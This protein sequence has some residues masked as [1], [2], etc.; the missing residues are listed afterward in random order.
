MKDEQERT[1]EQGLLHGKPLSRREFLRFAG[2]AGAVMGVGGG[3]SG[4]LAACG[5]GST[6]TTAAATTTA[7][8]SS[9]T[10]ATTATASSTASGSLVFPKNTYT[11][12][13]KTVTTSDG[14]KEVTYRL[15]KHLT[16]VANPV[17]A[18]YQSLNVSVPVKIP[19][20]CGAAVSAAMLPSPTD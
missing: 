17:D 11:E 4:L 16:Y 1:E 20:G 2:L 6:P 9:A 19:S 7:P 3:L 8:A 5:G 15:Y 12:Q 14:D 13:T 18:N 10:G